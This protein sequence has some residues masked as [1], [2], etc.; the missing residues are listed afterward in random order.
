LVVVAVVQEDSPAVAW[1]EK[2]PVLNGPEGIGVAEVD[3][4]VVA[5]CKTMLAF[6]NHLSHLGSPV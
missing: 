4:A 3:Q 5:R 1:T 2:R 6:P